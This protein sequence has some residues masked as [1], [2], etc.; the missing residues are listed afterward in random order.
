[1]KS[2]ACLLI[3]AAGCWILSEIL[4]IALG[5]RTGLTLGL[6]AAFHLFMVGGI[7]GAYAG[8]KGG[9]NALSRVAAAMVSLG[10]VMLVYP[11]IAVSQN[12]DVTIDLFMKAHPLFGMA[13]FLATLGCMLFGVAILRHRSYDRWIGFVLV[14]APAVFAVTMQSGG[15]G[16]AASTANLLEG[17]ALVAMG[18][19]GFN[20]LRDAPVP[21][22]AIDSA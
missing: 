1:M 16:V 19:R 2:L 21:S 10:F 5:G 14:V 22:V 9:P 12:P 6:T 20:T 13:G 3:A 17:V 7:W 15:L 11:P 18:L 8:Q 4:E